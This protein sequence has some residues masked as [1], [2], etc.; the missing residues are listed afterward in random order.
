MN[1][2]YGFGDK[3]KIACSGETGEVIGY[4]QFVAHK[5]QALV[6]YKAGDGRAVEHWW[7]VDALE[8]HDGTPA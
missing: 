8:I 6:R 2:L 4:A 3:V 7:D 1:P 5:D